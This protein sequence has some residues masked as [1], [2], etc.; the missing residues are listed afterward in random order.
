MKEIKMEPF[1]AYKLK[2]KNTEDGVTFFT[3]KLLYQGRNLDFMYYLQKKQLVIFKWWLMSREDR[4]TINKYLE[5]TL[6]KGMKL[7]KEYYI[8]A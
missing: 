4:A 7:R 5:K 2:E 3:G 1:K 6:Y 8:A